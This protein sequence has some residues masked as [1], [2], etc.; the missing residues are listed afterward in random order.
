M[1]YLREYRK[2]SSGQ[3]FRSESAAQGLQ[4]LTKKKETEQEEK[5]KQE[6]AANAS[7]KKRRS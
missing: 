7:N 4:T 2:L 3:D 6:K 1:D 5:R